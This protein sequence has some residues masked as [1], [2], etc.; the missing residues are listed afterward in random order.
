[1]EL[2]NFAYSNILSQF[3]TLILYSELCNPKLGKNH[4]LNAYKQSYILCIN[5]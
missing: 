4:P 5:S 3:D 1:M 2:V